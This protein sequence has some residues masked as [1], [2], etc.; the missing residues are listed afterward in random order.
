MKRADDIEIVSVPADLDPEV[1]DI[2]ALAQTGLL[3]VLNPEDPPVSTA[4]NLRR[5]LSGTNYLILAIETPR[6]ETSEDWK[7]LK[8]EQIL[9]T[10]S[11]FA[12]SGSSTGPGSGYLD[13]L[14]THPDRLRN[15]LAQDL[16]T[17][18]KQIAEDAGL[19][20]LDLTSGNHKQ[21]AQLFWVAQGFV[22]RPTN[23]YRYVTA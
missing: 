16:V 5:M 19:R 4:D 2:L 12:T 6:L 10:L 11:L 17:I 13:H 14:A 23:N 1:Y 8:P 7:A 9:A 22:P 3:R 21:A 20:R 18:A 15:H